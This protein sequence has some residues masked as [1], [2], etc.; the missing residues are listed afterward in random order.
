MGACSGSAAAL[1]S[2]AEC[3]KQPEKEQA[4]GLPLALP[5]LDNWARNCNRRRRGLLSATTGGLRSILLMR[6]WLGLHTRCGHSWILGKIGG[7]LR[8]EWRG[9]LPRSW[10]INILSPAKEGVRRGAALRHKLCRYRGRKECCRLMSSEGA[11][12]R[13]R[14]V[15]GVRSGTVLGEGGVRVGDRV[16]SHGCRLRGEMRGVRIV[17]EEGLFTGGGIGGR[18]GRERPR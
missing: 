4:R 12:E 8:H 11:G 13:R 6:L 5:W 9:V 15:L 10:W 18:R 16:R 3:Q 17:G 2:R 14:H 7:N 1:I